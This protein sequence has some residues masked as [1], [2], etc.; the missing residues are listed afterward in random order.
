[1]ERGDGGRGGGEGEG[2][3]SL[4]AFERE[5]LVRAHGRGFKSCGVAEADDAGAEAHYGDEDVLGGAGS[6]SGGATE[7]PSGL[8]GSADSGGGSLGVPHD[9]VLIR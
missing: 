7:F 4:I 6:E 3:G 2:R 5:A 1:M 8:D 9:S